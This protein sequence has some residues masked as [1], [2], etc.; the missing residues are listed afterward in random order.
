MNIKL[1]VTKLEKRAGKGI[2]C[3]AIYNIIFEGKTAQN[4]EPAIK[5]IR[6]F[7]SDKNDGKLYIRMPQVKMFN[8]QYFN[9]FTLP[10]ETFRELEEAVI[11]H[12]KKNHKDQSVKEEIDIDD[13]PF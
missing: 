12:Y 13:I 8:G 11:D 4:K 10:E 1:K 6:L 7:E 3:L 2:G 5:G 9:V